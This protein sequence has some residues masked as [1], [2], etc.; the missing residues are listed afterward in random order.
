[1]WAL[2]TRKKGRIVMAIT[3]DDIPEVDWSTDNP[4]YLKIASLAEILVKGLSHYPE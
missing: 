4:G 2:C 3:C 1:M